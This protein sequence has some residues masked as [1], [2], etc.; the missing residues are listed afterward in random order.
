[1][2]DTVDLALLA[3]TMAGVESEIGRAGDIVERLRNFLGK[4]EQRWCP[5][6]LA[7]TVHKVARL[8]ADE[9]R[10][11]GV[12][13]RTDLRPAA[14]VAAD[15][16]QIEQVLMNVIRNAIEAVADRSDRDGLV[17]IR[18]RQIDHEAQIEV[19]DN[20]PG[21]S[22][23]VAQHIFEPFETSKLRGMG[24][25]LWLSREITK[26]HGGSLCF[27]STVTTGARFVLRLPC[28]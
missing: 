21:V 23:E 15:R 20:G 18:L 3:R 1:M 22:P 16:I 28:S 26:A 2:S 8:L 24:F 25:G 17:W 19:E 4:S 27:D 7:S 14:R 5:I 10:S 12:T 13:I 6:D 11:Q 9:A